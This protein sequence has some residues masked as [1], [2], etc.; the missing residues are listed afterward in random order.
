MVEYL[1]LKHF[2]IRRQVGD[3]VVKAF[4]QSQPL[5][6]FLGGARPK[7]SRGPSEGRAS[8]ERQASKEPVRRARAEARAIDGEGDRRAKGDGARD[9]RAA[10]EHVS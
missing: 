6:S 1:L 3:Y 9:K 2:V 4:L 10:K 7:P 5:C 8:D